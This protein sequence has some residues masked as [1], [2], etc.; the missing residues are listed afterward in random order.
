[1]LNSRFFDKWRSRA[2]IY[3]KIQLSLSEAFIVPQHQADHRFMGRR[4]LSEPAL[5]C[6]PVPSAK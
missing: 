4:M 3:S 1:H 2:E 6:S 5:A